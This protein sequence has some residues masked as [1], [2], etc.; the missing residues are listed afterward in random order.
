[1]S[2]S[3]QHV[4]WS[5]VFCVVR[6]YGFPYVCFLFERR[7]IVE[8]DKSASL[9]ATSLPTGRPSTGA[10]ARCNSRS[11]SPSLDMDDSRA[12]PRR[13]SRES[14]PTGTRPQ[15]SREV[16]P[17]LPA[18]PSTANSGSEKTA[19]SGRGEHLNSYEKDGLFCSELVAALYQRLGLLDTPFPS[20]SD[21]VP[22][23]F[24]QSLTGG[25]A[26]DVFAPRS[27][28]SGAETG[29]G[30]EAD[31]SDVAVSCWFPWRGFLL[32]STV[33]PS[34]KHV[35]DVHCALSSFFYFQLISPLL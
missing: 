7:A 30:Q 13:S 32:L 34:L 8:R 26:R 21:Y 33:H 10:S 23:D 29:R 12:P 28:L 25:G 9:L 11:L 22:A 31:V 18:V 2:L 4:L 6:I 27:G 14:A 3:A 20:S 17:D 35:R 19:S 16:K 1:M 5:H 15:P 24:A